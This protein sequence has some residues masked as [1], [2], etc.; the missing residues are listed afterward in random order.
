MFSWLMWK[1]ATV[2][3]PFCLGLLLHVPKEPVC[4]HRKY[5]DFK[6]YYG[7]YMSKSQ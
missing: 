7:T 3:K 6:N 4:F 2:P 5:G 1:K